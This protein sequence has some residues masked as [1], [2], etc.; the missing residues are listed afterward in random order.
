MIR[1]DL[2]LGQTARIEEAN[3]CDGQVYAEGTNVIVHDPGLSASPPEGRMYVGCMKFSPGSWQ[4]AVEQN[5]FQN[6][7]RP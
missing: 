4:Q 7:F 1:G 5:W 6:C 3:I 2:N